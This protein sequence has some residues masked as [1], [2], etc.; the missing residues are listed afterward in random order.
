MLRSNLLKAIT[1]LCLLI[2][3][4]TGIYPLSL[5]FSPE[6]SLIFN[7]I[8]SI[9]SIIMILMNI[10]M[11]KFR[12][13]IGLFCIGLILCAVPLDLISSFKALLL[14]FIFSVFF[15]VYWYGSTRIA[16]GY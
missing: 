15:G 10:H 14:S 7:L 12:H 11:I 13:I 16:H 8:I 3:L 4:G 6:L 5:Y 9:I 1:Y 2:S